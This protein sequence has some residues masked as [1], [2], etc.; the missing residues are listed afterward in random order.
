MVPALTGAR[1]DDAIE[2]L[3]NRKLPAGRRREEAS[4]TIAAGLVI[5]TDPPWDD[6]S[7]RTPTSR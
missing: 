7:R 6:R 5:A 1:P 3:S 4:D 2:Q